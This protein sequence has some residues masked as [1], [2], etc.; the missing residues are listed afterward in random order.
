[1]NGE[2]STNVREAAIGHA[3]AWFLSRGY[4][5]SIPV[6]SVRYDLVVDS[7][8]GLQR[9]QVKSTTQRDRYGRWIVG[10]TR[11]AYDRLKVERNAEGQRTRQAYGV[12]EIDFFFIVVA[13]GSHYL[14]PVA[15]TAGAANI[16]LN[17]KY[18]AYRV[19]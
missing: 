12:D 8:S 10:I 1:M 17:Q 14:I 16:V 19:N 2:A 15:E 3:V 11:L 18:A 4:T 6:A 13:D 7:D 9:I 5:P